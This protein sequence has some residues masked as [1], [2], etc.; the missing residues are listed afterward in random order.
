MFPNLSKYSFLPIDIVRNISNCT[1]RIKSYE[2][3]Y[4]SNIP[5]DFNFFNGSSWLGNLNIDKTHPTCDCKLETNNRVDYTSYINLYEEYYEDLI[6]MALLYI[7]LLLILIV[8][9]ILIYIRY[10]YNNSTILTFPLLAVSFIG[11]LY[12]FY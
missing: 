7:S 3:Q 11:I 6:I 12:I 9:T 2:K 1:Y 8:I 10:L 5:E 4:P